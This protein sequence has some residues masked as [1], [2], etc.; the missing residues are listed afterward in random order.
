MLSQNTILQNRYRLLPA[1]LGAGL[2]GLLI[3]SNAVLPPGEAAGV[4]A[5]FSLA[6]P[7]ISSRQADRLATGQVLERVVCL[8][9]AQQSYALYL[10]T[11]YSPARSWPIL[12]AFDPMARGKLPVEHF[13]DAAEKYGWIVVG[14]NN[15]RNGPMKQATEAFKA[16]WKDTHERFAIDQGRVYATGF[17]GGARVAVFIA[18]I[19]GDCMAGVIGCGAGFPSG[20][21]P[22]PA[23]RFVFFGVVGVDDFN[24]PEV[25]ALDD[26]LLKAG[27][28]HNVRVFPGRHEWAPQPVATEAVEW[29]ELQAMRTRKRGRDDN[30]IEELWQK[31]FAAGNAFE[32]ANKP[33]E[34]YQLFTGLIG[35]FNGL[36]STSEAE[37]RLVQLRDSRAVKDALRDERQQISRQR[38]E[39]QRIHGL[40]DAIDTEETFD[41]GTRLRT[42]IAEL[43]KAAK[44]EIDTSARRV[45]RRV[46][47]GLFIGFFEQGL[48]L[49]Q[50]QK[51]Y[52]LAAK[53]LNSQFRSLPKGRVRFSIWHRLC[54]NERRPQEGVA[55]PE[56][57][58]R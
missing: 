56:E 9:D 14:S 55:I 25:R 5:S 41:S 46:S 1:I 18:N 58:D 22:A 13:K 44:A 15:S 12:Y 49:L 26:A 16:T 29:L 47:E 33:Y 6:T 17:S 31:Y 37:A 21:A 8:D 19:C 23:M 34:A 10:P 28:E 45:A 27:I 30:L 38:E 36:R 57:C 20:V 35:S 40:I 2:I 39:E 3:L 11:S 51:R 7:A 50:A 43:Q 52:N 53:S 32:L 4:A 48:N 42:S 54:A 24:F